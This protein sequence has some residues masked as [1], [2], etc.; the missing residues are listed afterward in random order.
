MKHVVGDMRKLLDQ[1]E[2]DVKAGTWNITISLPGGNVG[3]KI[4]SIK[5]NVC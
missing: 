1:L 5:K 3:K 2:C 4:T